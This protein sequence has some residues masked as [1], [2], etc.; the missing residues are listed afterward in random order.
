M[1]GVVCDTAPGVKDE[2]PSAYKD[3]TK[4]CAGHALHRFNLAL[5]TCTPALLL[6]HSRVGQPRHLSTGEGK[7]QACMRYNRAST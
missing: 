1:A 2:A 7:A 6:L 3:I 4:V 5:A